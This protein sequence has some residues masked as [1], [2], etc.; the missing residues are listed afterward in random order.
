MKYNTTIG[1]GKQGI[2]LIR[3]IVDENQC[4]FH[5]ILQE[6]DVGIDAFI[7]FTKDGKND[8]RCIAVQIKTGDSYF[9]VDKTICSIPIVDHY[10]Y[11]KNHSL[12]VFGIVCD[13]SKKTA[14][15][16]SISDYL[17]EQSNNTSANPVRSIKYSAMKLNE[18]T[19]ETFATIFKMRAYKQ[20][21]TI[22]CNQAL[23]FSYSSF[24]EEKKIS[25][26][27]L[28]EH[29][30]DRP[31]TWDR[32]L[33]MLEIENNPAILSEL[34]KYICYVPH[35]PDLWGDL[36][37]SPHTKEY[38]KSKMMT[39]S[40]NTI[41]KLLGVIDEWGIERGTI[42]H[43][44]ECI[45]S[46]IPG[47]DDILLNIIFDNLNDEIRLHAFAILAYNNTTLAIQYKADIE[48]ML[49]EIAGLVFDLIDEFGGYDPYS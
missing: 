16:V 49:G 30:S 46:T 37:Y 1:I 6:N 34:V 38:A 40:Q 4:Y 32:C 14:Y 10:E 19:S 2:N 13:I 9:N 8:G 41:V 24:F 44:V 23:E 28:M 25:I 47:I 48:K 31:E 12:E 42:G 3:S 11:W 5:E 20:L 33:A 18:L 43:C 26:P 15:W 36:T 27:I 29:Y 17:A 39:L 7:E 21:P 35:H 22:T 45:I